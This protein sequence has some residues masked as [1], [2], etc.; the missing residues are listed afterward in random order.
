MIGFGAKGN[1]MTSEDF[2]IVGY[3]TFDT[4]YESA[5]QVFRKSLLKHKV[6]FYIEGMESLGSWYKNTC[7]KPSFLLRM[8]DTFKGLNVVYVDC[9]A[10]LLAYPK[11]FHTIEGDV[12][13]HVMDRA[14]VYKRMN[15]SGMELLSGT[16]FLRN[17]ERVKEI[18]KAWA[19][20][21][22]R[23]PDDWDQVSLKRVLKGE[24]TELPAEY[25]KIFNRMNWITDPVI[26]HYQ[27]S[28][29]IR[30]NKHRKGS[31]PLR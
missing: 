6:L 31:L 25:C 4:I 30:N 8:L 7:Y 28:R 2:I 11:L 15:S 18:V 5:M 20:R 27:A 3:Y 1:K 22:E 12:A 17:N 13:V 9:D 21:C 26:V 19:H 24:Y 16:V 10:E 23:R 29:T 14:K